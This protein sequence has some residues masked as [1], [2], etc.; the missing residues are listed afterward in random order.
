MWL[1]ESVTCS[2]SDLKLSFPTLCCL[3]HR[4]HCG[5]LLTGRNYIS[6]RLHSD[7][8]AVESSGQGHLLTHPLTNN[9][10]Q[11][12][13]SQ[14]R[15]FL[16]RRQWYHLP[17]NTSCMMFKSSFFKQRK[18]KPGYSYT[19]PVYSLYRNKLVSE[20]F[21]NSRAI[22]VL[23]CTFPYMMITIF[24]R[25]SSWAKIGFTLL[26]SL[27]IKMYLCATAFIPKVFS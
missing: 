24:V 14:W 15:Q 27:S 4:Y 5:R 11:V 25:H 17:Q 12:L 18:I 13:T 6:S 7:V 2:I 20:M 1:I 22:R 16:K 8:D 3:W 19:I 21:H 26:R 9:T 23:F 10:R